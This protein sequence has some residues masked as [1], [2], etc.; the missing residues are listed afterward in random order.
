MSNP[1]N[2]QRALANGPFT[3]GVPFALNN[4]TSFDPVVIPTGA[5][6]TKIFVDTASFPSAGTLSVGW[7]GDND[8][9]LPAS[10]GVTTTMLGTSG[11]LYRPPALGY[12]A[13][14]DQTVT[15]MFDSNIASGQLNV[16]IE[17]IPFANVPMSQ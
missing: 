16:G 9:I 7:S 6:V 12:A 11:V 14:A 1:Y 10:A 13:T 3:T 17:Y 4:I 5:F 15:A 8:A 2:Y